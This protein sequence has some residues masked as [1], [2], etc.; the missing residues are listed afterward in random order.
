MYAVA[1]VANENV[2]VHNAI[3]TQPTKQTDDGLSTGIAK[4]YEWDNTNPKRHHR[5]P[6]RNGKNNRINSVSC[7]GQ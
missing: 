1:V 5:H 6:Y 3:E 7:Y 2:R 4:Y